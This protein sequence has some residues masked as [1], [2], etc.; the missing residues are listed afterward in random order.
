MR[1]LN[2]AV[3]FLLELA[4]FASLAYWGWHV[5]NT[6]AGVVLAV[7]APAVAIAVW[8]RYAAPRSPTRLPIR[9]RVP[10][11]LGVF[12]LSAVALA[13]SGHPFLAAIFVLVIAVNALG[14]TLY[15]QWEY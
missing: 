13:V 4:A 7:M 10:L 1:S 12:L 3:K 6:V 5:G 15:R 14:T 8:A 11:E 9:R 2:L